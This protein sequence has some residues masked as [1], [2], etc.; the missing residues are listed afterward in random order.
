M[1]LLLTDF[2]VTAFDCSFINTNI[3]LHIIRVIN[4]SQTMWIFGFK[5]KNGSSPSS[6]LQSTMSEQIFLILIY[7]E[8]HRYIMK[9]PF[10]KPHR[11]VTPRD[12]RNLS[13]F[14][15]LCWWGCSGKCSLSYTIWRVCDVFASHVEKHGG[16]HRDVEN[17]HNL[18]A[19]HSLP[20]LVAQLPQ[21]KQIVTKGD[22]DPRRVVMN[23]F[24][25][26][27]N[28]R[29]CADTLDLT[30]RWMRWIYAYLQQNLLHCLMYLNNGNVIND[31]N[32][33]FSAQLLVNII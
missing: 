9:Q 7:S 20:E 30:L 12:R 16:G 3:R 2:G 29:I 4:N 26:Y 33:S 13:P 31:N 6:S 11:E 32:M 10:P 25:F 8:T 21:S 14:P 19:H 15:S 28:N 22:R 1:L 24:Q 5:N 17:S 18:R 27:Y 23:Y